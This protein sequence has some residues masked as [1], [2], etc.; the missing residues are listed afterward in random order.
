MMRPMS[1]DTRKPPAG[2]ARLPRKVTAKSLEN[3]A[4]FYLERFATSAENLR[5]VLMR[6]VERSARA[7][8]TDPAEGAA[9]IDALI[10][11]FI[12]L[13]LLDDALYAEARARSLRRRGASG[14]AIALRLRQKGVDGDTIEAALAAAAEHEEEPEKAAAIRL[15]R[16]RRIGPWRPDA[17]RRDSREKDL[18]TL[19]RAGFSYDVALAVIDAET[20]EELEGGDGPPL[21]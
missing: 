18:A 7:H 14:R 20:I 16:K 17:S 21:A 13:D 11:R 15:A 9:W 5:R 19:A 10:A 8:G 3:A 1:E 6:R 12:T 2:K 4:L